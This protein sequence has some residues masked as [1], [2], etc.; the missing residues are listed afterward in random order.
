[1]N[2]GTVA[3]C[4]AATAGRIELAEHRQIHN[5][6]DHVALRFERDEI[7]PQ[8]IAAHIIARAIDRIDDPAPSAAGFGARAFFAQNAVVGKRVA[9]HARDHPLAL[10]IRLRHGRLIGL[11][12]RDDIRLV[13]ASAISAAFF[14]A[15]TATSSSFDQVFTSV[16]VDTIHTVA[17]LQ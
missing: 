11:G 14:A 10:A 1:M 6:H 4:P 15:S 16:D 8:R 13:L 12:L 2:A 9:Q 7:R 5:A 17:R 3:M